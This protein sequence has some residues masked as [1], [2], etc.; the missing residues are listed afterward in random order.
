MSKTIEIS[1]K[2]FQEEVL[3][4]NIPV[5]VDFWAPWC[6]P[7]LMMVPALDALSE[8]LEGKLKIGKMNTEDSENQVLAITYQIQSIPNMKLFK[9]GKVI[10]E[11]IGLRPKEG[12]RT[13]LSEVINLS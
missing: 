9:D 2:N 12:L 1:A 3:D 4:S 13:E 5:L 10:K 8:E 7:C 6:Q 11:F